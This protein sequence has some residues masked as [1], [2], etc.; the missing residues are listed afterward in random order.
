MTRRSKTAPPS[1][2]EDASGQAHT[3]A[4]GLLDDLKSARHD[5][6]RSFP[7]FYERPLL[8]LAALRADA[9]SARRRPF[10]SA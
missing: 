5:R 4:D 9:R 2:L 10:W 7:T 1:R 3:G 6:T 8:I